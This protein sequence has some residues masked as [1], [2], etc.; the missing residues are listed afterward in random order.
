MAKDYSHSQY[1]IVEFEIL[2][3]SH[4]MVGLGQFDRWLL[5]NMQSWS[6]EAVSFDCMK[7][8]YALDNLII[9][10]DNLIIP[11]EHKNDV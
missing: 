6:L 1:I 8:E 3:G 2:V 9:A 5:A 7:M 4:A 11:M 10:L